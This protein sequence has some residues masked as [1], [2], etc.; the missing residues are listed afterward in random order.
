M[1]L[2]RLAPLGF[3]LV[4]ASSAALAADPRPGHYIYGM[5]PVDDGG[6]WLTIWKVRQVLNF[7]INT[8]GFR[9]R[10]CWLEGTLVSGEARFPPEN[11]SDSPCIVNF[12]AEGN[13]IHVSSEGSSCSQFCGIGMMFDGTYEKKRTKRKKAP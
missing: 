8:Q 3:A 4:I 5:D 12:R 11:E 1:F 9:G 13:L 6:G 10:T 2:S 7:Q